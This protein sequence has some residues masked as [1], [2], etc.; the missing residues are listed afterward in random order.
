MLFAVDPTAAFEEL[1]LSS[2]AET[3]L[4]IL[5][6]LI[7]V[8]RFVLLSMVPPKITEEEFPPF[9][10][11][12]S[13]PN[14]SDMRPQPQPQTNMSE[15]SGPRHWCSTESRVGLYEVGG[16]RSEMRRGIGRTDV[17][18]RGRNLAGVC[19]RRRANGGSSRPAQPHATE[20]T[21]PVCITPRPR[22]CTSREHPT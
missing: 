13:R 21:S 5:N 19:W 7:D 6:Q 4:E 14:V 2:T 9:E 10:S 22:N 18:M 20:T 11:P 8:R 3:A 12:E 16:E 15:K 1:I 17:G